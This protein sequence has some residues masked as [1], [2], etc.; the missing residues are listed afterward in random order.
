MKTKR[1]LLA[2]LLG[3]IAAGCLILAACGGSSGPKITLPDDRYDVGTGGY[4]TL[5]VDFNGGSFQSLKDN[6]QIVDGT[7]YLLEQSGAS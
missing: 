7:N 5:T 3:L 4:L 1:K 2:L 6:G